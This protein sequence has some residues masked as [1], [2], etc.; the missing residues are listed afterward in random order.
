LAVHGCEGGVIS[1]QALIAKK[2]DNPTKAN[3]EIEGK[4]F[5]YKQILALSKQ[6]RS[7]WIGEDRPFEKEMKALYS[8]NVFRP[9]VELP[10]EKKP[11]GL[12]WVLTIKCDKSKKA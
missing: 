12:K 5:S 9:L 3:N 6:Q 10:Q 1:F 7:E 2:I 11:V 8:R 4:E